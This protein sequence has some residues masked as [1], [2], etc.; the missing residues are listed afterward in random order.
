MHNSPTKNIQAY[1]PTINDLIFHIK[2]SKCPKN[3]L[4]K[5]LITN[6]LVWKSL[7]ITFVQKKWD[8]ANW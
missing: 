1:H 4:K 3:N 7:F 8:I 5:T 6:T 2:L